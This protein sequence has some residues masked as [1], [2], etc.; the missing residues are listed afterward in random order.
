M[1]ASSLFEQKVVKGFMETLDLNLYFPVNLCVCVVS[2]KLKYASVK[3]YI[4]G[5]DGLP[6]FGFVSFGCIVYFS[7]YFV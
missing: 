2:M 1:K 5:I 6:T 4:G 7:N 3:V